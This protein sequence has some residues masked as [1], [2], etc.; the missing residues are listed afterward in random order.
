ME[1]TTTYPRHNPSPKPPV[2]P[3]DG[4]GAFIVYL[5]QTR[6]DAA[7]FDNGYAEWDLGPCHQH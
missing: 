4:L 3:R 6:D 2:R 5:W 7:A 1:T